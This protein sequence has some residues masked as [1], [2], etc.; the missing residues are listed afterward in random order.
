MEQR[1]Q[2]VRKSGKDFAVADA[3]EG[4][5]Y[6][7]YLTSSTQFAAGNRSDF[8]VVVT[9]KCRK[10]FARIGVAKLGADFAGRVVT[11][12]GKVSKA[13][14]PGAGGHTGGVYHEPAS[15]TMVALTIDSLDQFVSVR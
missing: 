1:S 7:V 9:D 10:D 3:A 12:R 15:L 2:S 13:T 11:M 8:R 4:E 5:I 14:H 6:L